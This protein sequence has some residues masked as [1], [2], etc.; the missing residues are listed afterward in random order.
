MAVPTTV[1]APIAE[2]IAVMRSPSA[3]S[4][5]TTLIAPWMSKKK[6]SSGAS[7]T[8]A[9]RPA[10]I[11]AFQPSYASRSSCPPGRARAWSTPTYSAAGTSK[12]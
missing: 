11:S 9:R 4:R 1:C 5:P 3:S 12:G 8:A 2:R 10:T 6:P 7:S